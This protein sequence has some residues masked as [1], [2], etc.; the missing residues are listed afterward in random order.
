MAS[1]TGD[2][3]TDQNMDEFHLMFDSVSKYMHVTET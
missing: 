3:Q 2:E 1:E